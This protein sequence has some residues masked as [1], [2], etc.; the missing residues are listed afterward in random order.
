MAYSRAHDALVASP[1]YA[2]AVTRGEEVLKAVQGTVAYQA[3]A[4]RI[5]PLAAP[6]VEPALV[7]AEPYLTAAVGYL[8][9]VANPEAPAAAAAA[10]GA[11]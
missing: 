4:T 6:Y 7:K 10:P 1:T 3:A 5:Y 2:K 8:A 11:A 9:P